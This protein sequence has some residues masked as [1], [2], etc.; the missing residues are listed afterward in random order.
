[1]PEYHGAKNIGI[2][3]SMPSGEV[4]TKSIVLDALR[5]GKTVFVPYIYKPL[6]PNGPAS[7]MD[8]V[9]LFSEEDFESLPQDRW[10]IPTPSKS[11]L[12][13][14]QSYFGKV[15]GRHICGK[16]GK[17]D[18]ILMPGVA[19]DKGRRRL[20]HGKGYYDVFLSQYHNQAKSE[21][22]LETSGGQ[23]ESHTKYK[24]P[25]LGESTCGR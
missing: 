21:Q 19:F 3:L 14:R 12:A 17:L 24:M 23:V 13:R 15:S 5:N 4:M 7:M 1:M 18:V 6:A 10:G 20:G 9:S 2:Y 25:L 8:M 16:G 22:P 11:S